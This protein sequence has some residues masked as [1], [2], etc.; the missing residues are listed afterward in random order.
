MRALQSRRNILILAVL[1]VSTAALTATTVAILGSTDESTEGAVSVFELQEREELA[2]TGP[3]LEAPQETD[4]NTTVEDDA[5][6]DADHRTA[7]GSSGAVN[8]SVA[9]HQA[10]RTFAQLLQ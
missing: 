1:I 9:E 5:T 8:T 3:G 10:Y 6:E 4:E 2:E 7:I